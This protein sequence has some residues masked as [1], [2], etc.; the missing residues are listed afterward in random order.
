MVGE[1][2]INIRLCLTDDPVG[3]HLVPDVFSNARRYRIAFVVLCGRL[4]GVYVSLAVIDD[5][6]N[7]I[8]V[9]LLIELALGGGM[10]GWLGVYSALL[11][12]LHSISKRVK[13]QA[14]QL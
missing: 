2:D 3:D 12:L 1:R 13:S 11:A 6:L 9:L 5:L 14:P 4:N 10:R 8:I 7:G